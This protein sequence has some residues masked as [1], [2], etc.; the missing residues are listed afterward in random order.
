[1]WWADTASCCDARWDRGQWLRAEQQW[2]LRCC[3][4]AQR[5][6]KLARERFHVCAVVCVVV[7]LSVCCGLCLFTQC[8]QTPGWFASTFLL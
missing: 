8:A 5:P 3:D 4:D 1:M 7:C 2:L 6:G